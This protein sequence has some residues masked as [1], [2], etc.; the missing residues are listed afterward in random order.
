MDDFRFTVDTH[1]FRE[2]GE[3]LVGR[4]STALIELI[5]NAYDAD[6]TRVQVRGVDLAKSGTIEI[7][8][9]GN[10][11]TGEVFK[12]AFLR[13]AGRYKEGG[14]RRSP[15]YGRRYTGA[16]G[17]GRLSA[18]KLARRLEV[19]SV[20]NAEVFNAEHIESLAGVRA[21]I[22]WD[23]LENL[24]ET[25]DT[26]TNGLKV[27]VLASPAQD[28]SGTT[29]KLSSLKSSWQAAQLNR[30]LD[31]LHSARPAPELVS[32]PGRNIVSEDTLIGEVQPSSTGPNDPGFQII[33]EG[34]LHTGESLWAE[35]ISR[36]HWLLEI[37]A[38]G[39]LVQYSIQPTR[40]YSERLSDSRSYVFTRAHPAPSTGPHFKA[41]IYAREGSLGTKNRASELI[42]FNSRRGGV[43]VY[44]EGFRVLPYGGRRDDW[45]GLDRDYARKPRTFEIDL[46]ETSSSVL[47]PQENE[48]FLSQGND[49]YFGA[50]FLTADG[51]ESLRPVVNREGFVEDE[52]F[53]VLRDLTR[54]GI[55][56]VTR[57]RAANLRERQ[58]REEAEEEVYL[59]SRLV[60]GT[61]Q[62]SEDETQA[63][64]VAE[65]RADQT[66]TPDRPKSTVKRPLITARQELTILGD[67]PNLPQEA[68]AQVERAQVAVELAE[69]RERAW[70]EERTMLRVLAGVGLQFAAFVHEI[71][72]ILGQANTV[73]ELANFLV[74]A[75][76]MERRQILSQLSDAVDQ[77]VQSLARQS[78]YLTDVVGP[79][80]RR[81]R[82]RMRLPEIVSSSTQLLSKTIR[83][84]GI[85]L[86]LDLES[87]A[88]TPPMFPA[89]MTVIMTNLLT[90]AV[91][92][93]GDN[94]KVI[95]SGYED[96]TGNTIIRVENTGNRVDLADSE[97]WFQPF[98]STTTEID[99][100]LGQGLGLGLPITRR[101]IEEYGG[102]IY[103]TK[104]TAGFATAVQ[105]SLPPRG[106]K[107]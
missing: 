55:D 73:R 106:V 13:I 75:S 49:Q 68:R 94:G 103:F 91:K 74:S 7:I 48:G 3:L 104:P 87:R 83:E 102:K 85:H 92:A 57:A 81:R 31:E 43:R 29:L 40:A 84:R 50:V 54:T 36:S 52:S 34:D 56:L 46:A 25:L 82:R 38:T 9:D 53:E 22:D 60:Q 15:L 8:D 86:T 18:H 64:S 5:K 44:L 30:F 32:A 45:L 20:P 76:P 10:G 37:D 98:E 96:G 101:I 28:F 23:A 58:A 51:A 79:D 63:K 77:L 95:V 99:V 78:S 80:A 90:N 42:R 105:I 67:T 2:L 14:S 107:A 35:L 70:D 66:P 26:A 62:D 12:G 100:V 61:P 65:E 17:V 27:E 89:E 21:Q 1:L 41:R 6:A 59:Q 72:G 19:T 24:N 11:M 97:R 88:K 33:T 39:P 16:K 71:N 69:S 47:L 4:D 93:I